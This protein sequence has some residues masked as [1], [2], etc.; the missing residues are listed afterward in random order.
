[1]NTCNTLITAHSGCNNTL[2]NTLESIIV[3]MESGADFVEVDVRSTKDG[4]PVLFH[5]DFVKTIDHGAVRI[6]D[7]TLS[8]LNG[9]I[10]TD[11]KV[12]NQITEIITFDDAISVAKEFGGLLNVDIKDDS[13]IVPM[14]KAVREADMVDSIV[15]T[16]CEYARA[17]SLKKNYPEFQVLLNLNE[18]LLHNGEKSVSKIAD[19]I[20]MMAVKASCCGINI[21]FTYLSDELIQAARKRYL[22]ISIWTLTDRNNLDDYLNMGLYSITTMAASLLV[23]KRKSFTEK[24]SLL[25]VSPKKI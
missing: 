5:E 4:L 16:G 6:C 10:K 25:G 11:S 9:L 17:A 7:F 8:E 15:I 2:P 14:V 22:P 20:C 19:E 21:E 12:K 3:G 13:C 23:E 1:M 24:M 18:D